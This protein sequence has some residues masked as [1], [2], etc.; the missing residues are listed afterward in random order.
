MKTKKPQLRR[1][2]MHHK[3]CRYVGFTL[4]ELLVVIAIIAILAGLLLPA[5]NSA[6]EKG[7]R[8]ACAS[9]LKQLGAGIMAYSGDNGNHFV[10]V[11][12]NNGG[13]CNSGTGDGVWDTA[14]TNS[15]VQTV[16]VFACPDD[17][18]PRASGAS[19]RSYAVSCGGGAV[20]R[21]D[22]WIQG[23]RIS[24]SRFN[25]DAALATE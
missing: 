5:L 4:I 19:A 12:C 1:S 9:N 17:T 15:Y 13:S 24:C 6:R 21:S 10:T 3:P 7:K 11:A 14:L 25:S 2:L 20:S 16:K 18:T 22:Y 23:S 8:I